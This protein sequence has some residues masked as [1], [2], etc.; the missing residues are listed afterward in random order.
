MT[1]DGQTQQNVTHPTLAE[2]VADHNVF[3]L[4]RNEGKTVRVGSTR[5]TWK[6]RGENTGYQFAVYEMSL[7]P[8]NGIPLHKHAY[9]EFFYVLEGQVDFG[10]M[11]ADGRQEWLQVTAGESVTVPINAPHA[12]HNRTDRP[13]RFLEVS[14]HY[15]EILFDK[16]AIEIGIDDPLPTEF[17]PAELARFSEVAAELQGFWVELDKDD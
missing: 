8:N 3:K 6:T 1:K 13:A 17:D 5:L 9:P 2:E 12:F 16:A 4:G 10:R 7:D 11:G 14:V 15:H